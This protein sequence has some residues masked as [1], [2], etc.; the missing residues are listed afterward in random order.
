MVANVSAAFGRGN[1]GQV[2]GGSWSFEWERSSFI[3]RL[4]E[5]EEQKMGDMLCITFSGIGYGVRRMG[6]VD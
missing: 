6:V 5:L 2:R 4:Q 3:S 1:D